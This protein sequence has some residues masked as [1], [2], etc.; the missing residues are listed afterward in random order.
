MLSYINY[1]VSHEMCVEKN[2]YMDENQRYF[3]MRL[4]LT[5]CKWDYGADKN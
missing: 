3:I 1:E 2:M 4:L 5:R